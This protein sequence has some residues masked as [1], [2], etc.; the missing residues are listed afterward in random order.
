MSPSVWALGSNIS[1]TASPLNEKSLRLPKKTSVGQAPTG[2][3]VCPA[4]ASSKWRSVFSCA[5]MNA[6]PPPPVRLLI[7]W[8]KLPATMAP[9]DFEIVSFPPVVGVIV[10]VDDQAD[11]LALRHLVDLRQQ[12]LRHAGGS[13]VDHHYSV[14]TDA[15]E[16][17]GAGADEHV[18]LALDV[19][20]LDFSGVRAPLLGGDARCS[21]PDGRHGRQAAHHHRRDFHVWSPSGRL[22]TASGRYRPRPPSRPKCPCRV[23]TPAVPSRR[24]RARP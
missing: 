24:R 2:S 6:V 1:T 3:A 15:D 21:G 11:R 8:A 16:D 4:G 5:K 12:L 17:V 19:E 18:D 23:R 10:G 13:T 7:C 14:V 22:N 20:S 9:P